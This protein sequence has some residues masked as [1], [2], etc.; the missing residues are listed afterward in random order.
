[1]LDEKSIE[2]VDEFGDKLRDR[3]QVMLRDWL[4]G[5]GIEG[6]L[7]EELSLK[8]AGK[9]DYW[10][11]K[12]RGFDRDG[13]PKATNK[14]WVQLNNRTYYHP[15]YSSPKPWRLLS[16]F[17]SPPS[18][19]LWEKKP[20]YVYNRQPQEWSPGGPD[21]WGVCYESLAEALSKQSE[22]DIMDEILE[23]LHTSWAYAFGIQ[24]HPDFV[25]S[26]SEGP[27]NGEQQQPSQLPQDSTNIVKP[28]G[29]DRVDITLSI[30]E[31]VWSEFRVI[32]HQQYRPRKKHPKRPSYAKLLE[33]AVDSALMS[34]VNQWKG[35]CE[36]EDRGSEE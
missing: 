26:G 22:N 17:S 6:E 13:N 16:R 14:N 7:L 8:K 4:Q 5:I 18:S 36:G 35:L 23:D 3:L 1:M 32:V 20:P 10:S 25:S 12:V 11:A 27:D 15:S 31:K 29:E 21:V 28:E 30:D 24:L 33:D 9:S 34:Y 2:Q 19:L